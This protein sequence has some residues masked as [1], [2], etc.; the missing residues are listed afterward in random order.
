[1]EFVPAH[2]GRTRRYRGNQ[3]M[4]G[5]SAFMPPFEV[6]QMRLNIDGLAGTTMYQF[7]ATRKLSA[8]SDTTSLPS[9]I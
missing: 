9:P 7:T 8:F 5:P 4:W 3:A 6:A 1:M 2:P